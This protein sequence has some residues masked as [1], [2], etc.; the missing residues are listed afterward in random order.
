MVSIRNHDL[1]AGSL[2]VGRFEGLDA[3]MGGHHNVGRRL[4]RPMGSS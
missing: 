4:N 1:G 3:G 2:N